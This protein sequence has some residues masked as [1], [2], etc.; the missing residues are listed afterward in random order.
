M[1]KKEKIIILAIILNLFFLSFAIYPSQVTNIVI[2]AQSTIS[3]DC[4]NNYTVRGEKQIDIFICDKN[5]EPEKN[6]IAKAVRGGNTIVIQE[7]KVGT[8]GGYVLLH[9]LGHNLGY[10]HDNSG[11]M[12]PK[13]KEPHKKHLSKIEKEIAN[14]FKGLKIIKWNNKS[15]IK[16]IR[17]KTKINKNLIGKNCTSI[18]YKDSIYK[19]WWDTDRFYNRCHIY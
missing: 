19:S 12:H 14:K 9:E 6:V 7:N 4:N 2:K 5:I 10:K 16:Y 17:N 3:E 8:Y 18:Y 15:D 13:P 11:I 1:N